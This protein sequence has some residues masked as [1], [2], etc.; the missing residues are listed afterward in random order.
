[1]RGPDLKA[2]V[3]RSLL[4]ISKMVWHFTIGSV[5]WLL[6]LCEVFWEKFWWRNSRRRRRRSSRSRK[7]ISYC[8]SLFSIDTAM[9]NVQCAAYNHDLNFFLGIYAWDVPWIGWCMAYI[10]RKKHQFRAIETVY[11]TTVESG[12]K[13]NW[14]SVS[15]NFHFLCWLEINSHRLVI[16]FPLRQP[17]PRRRYSIVSDKH[18]RESPCFSRRRRRRSTEEDWGVVGFILGRCA[19]T[20]TQSCFVRMKGGGGGGGK[21]D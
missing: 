10:W 17:Q 6:E 18:A 7:T 1:M 15:F 11:F 13:L 3:E 19:L 4:P 12:W 8:L 5:V 20:A 2:C 21:E 9:K 16:Y 14:T